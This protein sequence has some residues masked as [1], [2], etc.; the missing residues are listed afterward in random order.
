MALDEKGDKQQAKWAG[1]NGVPFLRRVR[2]AEQNIKCRV[3]VCVE[4]L[5]CCC[6]TA[7]MMASGKARG[8]MRAE[9][10]L[11]ERTVY[12]YSWYSR[13]TLPVAIFS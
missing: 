7:M 5:P 13:R 12:I 2:V 6:F 10:G 3:A 4:P 11:K 1:I 9:G 8:K